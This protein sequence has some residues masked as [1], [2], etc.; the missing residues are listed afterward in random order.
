MEWME[1]EKLRTTVFKASTN[2][3]V[4]SFHRTLNSMLAI[5]VNDNQRN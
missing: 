1:I 4:E 5:V 2:G 3:V